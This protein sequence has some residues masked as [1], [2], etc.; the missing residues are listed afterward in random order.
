MY[1]LYV[2]WDVQNTKLNIIGSTVNLAITK[3]QLRCQNKIVLGIFLPLNYVDCHGNGKGA[4]K[5][6]RRLSYWGV[7][8]LGEC[9]FESGFKWTLTCYQD[10]KIIPVSLFRVIPWMIKEK[11]KGRTNEIH[12]TDTIKWNTMGFSTILLW[13]QYNEIVHFYFILFVF[14]GPH[15]WHMDVPRLGVQLELQLLASSTATATRDPSHDCNLHHS[16]PQLQ[17]LNP[18]REARDQKP[19]S[20]WV[21]VGFVNH[22]ATTGTP[23]K[24]LLR[25]LKPWD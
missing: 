22:W 25:K 5:K 9:S 18:L 23:S 20:S 17:I 3:N 6:W 14:L 10:P 8:S 21:L 7:L 13:Q 11:G 19:T 24:F 15:P 4:G 12:V 1:K 16:S 2:I